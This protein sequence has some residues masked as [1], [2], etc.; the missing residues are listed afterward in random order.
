MLLDAD[1]A[2]NSSKEAAEAIAHS[3][4]SKLAAVMPLKFRGFATDSG[5]GGTLHLLNDEL[6]LQGVSDEL[7]RVV[8]CSLHNLKTCLRNAVEEV[9]GSGGT[10]EQKKSNGKD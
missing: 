2:G 7:T 4:K 10:K 8:S 6:M 3:L 5:G 1:S 9:F